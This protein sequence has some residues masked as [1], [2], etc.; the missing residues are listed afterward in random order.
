MR[1]RGTYVA[2]AEGER[3]RPET[4]AWPQRA[5]T[6]S[7]CST[8]TP[9]RN[10]AGSSR[11]W[12]T[13][14]T[15]RS[16]WSPPHRRA[17]RRGRPAR[18][19]RRARRRGHGA[20]P[21]GGGEGRGGGPRGLAAAISRYEA[22]RS[23][24][25][26]GPDPARVVARGRVPFVPGAAL[27]VR[28]HLRFDEAFD[29]GGEDVDFVR[30]AGYVRYEPQA[31][32]AHDHRTDPRKWLQRRV[33]YGR[34]AAPLAIEHNDHARPLDISPWTTAAWIALA[35]RRPISAVAITA[36]ASGLLAREVRLRTAVELAG[37]GTLNS[38]RVVADALARAWWP[39]SL[40]LGAEHAQSAAAGRRGLRDIESG[41]R[42]QARRRPRVRLRRMGGMRKS[43]DFGAHQTLQA[44]EARQKNALIAANGS[45]RAARG[46][47]PL[48]MGRDRGVG[49]SP[50]SSR[51]RSSRSCRRSPLTSRTPSRTATPSPRRS[52]TRST[53]ASRAARRSPRSSCTRRTT[54]TRS[55][56]TA[57]SSAPSAAS[58]TSCASPRP[59]RSAAARSRRS[60]TSSRAR[61]R[62]PPRTA[63]RT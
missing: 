51:S 50:R 16:T 11:C 6:S 63:R 13:S 12:P 42:A 61:S 18:R 24:L 55:P 39:A 2:S 52:T 36:I 28:R 41:Q 9:S 23:P 53:P 8:P 44:M 31:R 54:R 35:A 4:T 57:R 33:Y 17:R 48:E 20:G 60:P 46:R 49:R 21:V 58:P 32:V 29:R 15:P 59:S 14:P 1:V 37:L 22:R 30:R 19:P 3:R 26:R 62:T 45:D 47:T 7:R 34:T 25:D 56:P 40:A 5:T 27:V 43:P 10:P 38:G